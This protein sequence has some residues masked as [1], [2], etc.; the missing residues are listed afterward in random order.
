LFRQQI[1]KLVEKCLE[2]QSEGFSPEAIRFEILPDL[3]KP[4]LASSDV[5]L[6][7]VKEDNQFSIFYF[8]VQERGVCAKPVEA[9]ALILEAIVMEALEV[10]SP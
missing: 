9:A 5:F 10:D 7:W 1:H 8:E 3:V 2:A 4:M 6:N